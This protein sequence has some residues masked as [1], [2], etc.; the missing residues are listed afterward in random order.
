MDMNKYWNHLGIDIDELDIIVQ[1][2]PEGYESVSFDEAE[3]P[4]EYKAQ[5]ETLLG[6]KWNVKKGSHILFITYSGEVIAT[7]FFTFENGI[8]E[9]WV[10]KCKKEHRKKGFYKYL[11]MKSFALME[12]RDVKKVIAIT[13]KEYL[14]PFYDSLGFTRGVRVK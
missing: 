6:R 9:P 4:T 1:D 13:S 5:W 11:M 10:G 3:V 2:L 14:W 7:S 8:G 12:E